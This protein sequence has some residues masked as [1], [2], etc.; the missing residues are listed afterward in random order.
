VPLTEFVR[1]A[2]RGDLADGE[3]TMTQAG[4][5]RVVLLRI[6][7][8]YFAIAWLC[9]HALG[10]LMQGEL[11][12]YEI[13]CPIHEGRFD[14]RTGAV[15]RDPPDEKIEPLAVYT[16]RIEGDDIYVGPGPAA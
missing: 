13:Q 9:T 12:G 1:I 11:H 3:I 2:R 7:E 4:G 10:L 14:V 6:G 8:E 15:T 16:V 5:E